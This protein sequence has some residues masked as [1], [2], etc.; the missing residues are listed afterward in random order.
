MK[1]THTRKSRLALIAV[2]GVLA[3]AGLVTHVFAD[4]PPTEPTEP[5]TP[6][7][8]PA[9]P[10]VKP[11][12]EPPAD[13]GL[14]VSY[15]YEGKTLF[16][17]DEL[18]KEM[19]KKTFDSDILKII[20]ATDAVFA[21]TKKEVA[22]FTP[23]SG[24]QRWSYKATDV[25]KIELRDTTVIILSPSQLSVVN[26]DTG[27]DAWRIK[28]AGPITEYIILDDRI[29]VVPTEKRVMAFAYGSGEQLATA[30]IGNNDKYVEPLLAGPALA[31][32]FEK[33]I[34]LWNTLRKKELPQ[35][36]A[37]VLEQMRDANLSDAIGD[38]GDM[39][40]AG[41]EDD[42]V[43]GLA[44]LLYAKNKEDKLLIVDA[45]ASKDENIVKTAQG[46][47]AAMAEYQHGGGDLLG[48]T[49]SAIL[50]KLAALDS[51]GAVEKTFFTAYYTKY[52]YELPDPAQTLSTLVTMLSLGDK[53]LKESAIRS[54]EAL[55]DK[56]FEYKSGDSLADRNKAVERWQKWLK[57]NQ[58][59]F[60]WDIP[61][62]KI[63][64]RE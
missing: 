61:N 20:T 5:T 60:M 63:K 16:A 39:V 3:I 53:N 23:L 58:G 37:G 32:R 19:W 41:K 44:A 17:N 21:V 14:K 10:P 55:T 52:S 4:T 1:T 59:K 24:V 26:M 64:I 35:I 40:A 33:E 27:K 22:L 12:V 62:R 36:K 28:G 8:P 31:L 54:L 42:R 13:E 57:D 56:T 38:L 30:S 46:I 9:E 34:R 6:A 49:T 15:R 50:E 47:M 25:E 45:L 29:M 2:A 11:P 7:E 43:A 18:G 51:S 48:P